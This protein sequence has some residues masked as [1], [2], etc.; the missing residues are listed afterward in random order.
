M[1]VPTG[2]SHPAS[3]LESATEAL[4]AKKRRV[5]LVDQPLKRL[6][7][8]RIKFRSQLDIIRAYGAASQNGNRPVNYRE[9]AERYVKLDPSTVSLLNPFLAENGF[10]ERSGNDLIPS[11]PVLEFAMAYT[12]SAETAARKLLPIIERSWFGAFLRSKLGFKPMP[13][14]EIVAELAHEIAAGPEFKP[15]ISLL[16]DYAEAAGLLR[17]DGNQ[18][19]PL[20]VIED[21]M[22]AS[23]E[24]ATREHTEQVEPIRDGSRT[25]SGSVGTGF[26]STEGVV[27]F[28]VSIRVTMQEMA[29]WSPDRISAFFAGLAQVLAAKHGAEEVQ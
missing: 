24:T 16:I 18:L 20:A 21:S 6:P 11:K 14:N 9:V 2:A 17:R 29:S 1:D 8:E 13:E 27:Q 15:R 10:V 25:T 19:L 5:R 4:T 22:P 7:T 3:S 26:M 12:W 23:A 28:H